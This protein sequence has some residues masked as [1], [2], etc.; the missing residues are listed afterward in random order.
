MRQAQLRLA[1]ISILALN[2]YVGKAQT[3][4]IVLDIQTRLP[5]TNVNIFTDNNKTFTTNKAGRFI[6][7]TT[8][9][10]VTITHGNYI[11]RILNRKEMQDTIFLLPKSITVN[12]VIITAKAPRISPD[13]M[14][15]V[16]KSTF[17]NAQQ[18]S[19]MNF[20]GWLRIFE[21]GYV[22]KKERAK[23]R[24]AIENY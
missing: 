12:E 7:T 11:R 9:G 20:L 16:K 4:G 3:A 18:P 10:S 17:E 6:I 24:K 19:G 5:I 1:V 8:F 23:R 2:Q 21:K 22:S 14:K 15:S 13:I